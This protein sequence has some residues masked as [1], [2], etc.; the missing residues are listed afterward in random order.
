MYVNYSIEYMVSRI[1]LGKKKTKYK[2]Q[3]NF[4]LAINCL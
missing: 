3:N 2:G 4:L 1:E